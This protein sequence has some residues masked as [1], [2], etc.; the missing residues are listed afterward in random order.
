[1]IGARRRAECMEGIAWATG[2][3]AQSKYLATW[4][5]SLVFDNLDPAIAI[6]SFTIL[7]M[8]QRVCS[9]LSEVWGR[10]GRYLQLGRAVHPDLQEVGSS[11]PQGDPFSPLGLSA[12]LLAPRSR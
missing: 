1:M 4:D 7:G 5:Y 3:V 2:Q 6:E 10:Q 9:M 11:L 12:V 8:D